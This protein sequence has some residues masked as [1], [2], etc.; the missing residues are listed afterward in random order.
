MTG[1]S[2]SRTGLSGIQALDYTVV[3]VRDMEAMRAF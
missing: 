1:E 2:Q 3:R